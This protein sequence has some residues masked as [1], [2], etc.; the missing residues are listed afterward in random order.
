MHAIV[1]MMIADFIEMIST[2]CVIEIIFS[3]EINLILEQ[4]LLIANGAQ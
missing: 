1:T 2:N 4:Q 3:Q